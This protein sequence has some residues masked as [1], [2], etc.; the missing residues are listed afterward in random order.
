MP[1]DRLLIET[2]APFLAPQPV[3]GAKNEPAFVTHTAATLA[4]VR[5]VTVDSIGVVT[6]RNARQL[7]ALPG[8]AP[9][10]SA[11]PGTGPTGA[12]GERG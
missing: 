12:D 1:D 9:R 4:Q 6:S 3:R 2:D 11:G 5:G 8:L 7:F 10:L